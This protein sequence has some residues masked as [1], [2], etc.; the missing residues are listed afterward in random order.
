MSSVTSVTIS[1]GCRRVAMLLK[2][3]IDNYQRL[4]RKA[5]LT[6]MV[7]GPTTG[8]H[9]LLGTDLIESVTGW[10]SP[11]TIPW[12][13]RCVRSARDGSRARYRVRPRPL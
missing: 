12:R 6:E 8:D 9:V 3:T 13:I 2:G 7:A 5:F 4:E 11:L 1:T 10:K